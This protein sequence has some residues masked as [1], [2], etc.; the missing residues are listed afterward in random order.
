MIQLKHINKTFNGQH[1]PALCDINLEIKTGEFLVILGAS[2]SGKSTTLKMINRLIE[3]SSGH[4]TIDGTSIHD[5]G[6]QTLRRRIGYVFQGIGLF[7]H[8]SVYDNL[9]VVLNLYH[10]NKEH[11]EE[12]IGRLLKLVNLDLTPYA[13][14][15]PD[16]LSGGQQQR[17]GVARALLGNPDI[18]LMDEPF[19]ALDA[20]NRQ[21]LQGELLKL[22]HQLKK[23]TVFVTHDLLEAFRLCDRI[24]IFNQ[25]QLVQ[26]GTKHELIQKPANV[27]VRELIDQQRQQL[28]QL[29]ETLQ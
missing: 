7:P 6:L 14:R 25:G 20:I 8:L 16:E 4:I 28:Q 24:A 2:G 15:F 27:Y 1:S 3:P 18:L 10:K 21:A 26:I 13:H 17:V 19:G 29:S 11:Q 22:H 9:R 12:E 5:M 23:T